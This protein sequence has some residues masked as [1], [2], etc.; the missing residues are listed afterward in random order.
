MEIYNS[1]FKNEMLKSILTKDGDLNTFDTIIS[2]FTN[3]KMYASLEVFDCNVNDI[4]DWSIND[5]SLSHN[6]GKYF[7]VLG[8]RCRVGNREMSEWYQPIIRQ[9]EEGITGFIIKKING[10]YHL[11]VQAK[12]EAGNFDVLEMAPTVQC[13]TGSYSNPEYTVTYL[14]YFLGQKG[15][16]HFD[17]LQ[18]E[19]GGRFYQEQNQN[20]VLEVQEDELNDIHPN[21]VWMTVKQA[22]AFIKFNNYFNIEARS[23]LACITPV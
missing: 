18:S 15:I 3:L 16:V 7:E 23:I 5:L 11:L 22:K 4:R 12:L 10:V 8:V 1:V 2:W 21:F 19:E 6:S 13:I 9:R 14:D 20:I 17:T